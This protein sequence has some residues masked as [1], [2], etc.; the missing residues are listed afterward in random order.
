MANT[1]KK[2]IGDFTI[3]VVADPHGNGPYCVRVFG[4][5][6]PRTLACRF[7]TQHSA[8]EYLSHVSSRTLMEVTRG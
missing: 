7:A 2:R 1:Y 3:R 4:G 5:S 6:V 8:A